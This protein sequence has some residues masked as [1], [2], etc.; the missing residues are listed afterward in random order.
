MAI[1]V[2]YLAIGFIYAS[3]ILLF[4]IDE[5]YKFPMNMLLAPI[6]L[7]FNLYKAY[8]DSKKTYL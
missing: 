7:P 4:G 5:W 6:I 1:L 3:Y 2:I 8:K